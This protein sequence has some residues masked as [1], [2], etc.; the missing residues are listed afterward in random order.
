MPWQAE[1][2]E[3]LTRTMI[4]HVGRESGVRRQ[5]VVAL[6][7]MDGE[8]PCVQRELARRLKSLSPGAYEKCRE[9]CRVSMRDLF[10]I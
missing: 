3:E 7:V 5:A 9:M 8:A 2:C 1:L 4:K 10:E 6:A